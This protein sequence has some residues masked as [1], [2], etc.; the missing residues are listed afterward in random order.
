MA[1][2]PVSESEKL[3][4]LTPYTFPEKN[5]YNLKITGSPKGNARFSN[6]E[7]NYDVRV[8][9]EAD[10]SNSATEKSPW[11]SEHLVHLV[12]GGVIV[13]FFI[14]AL[15]IQNKRKVV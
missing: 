3:S 1:L 10:V 9:R 12:G 11:L 8:S 6:F 4:S 15:I 14:V 7:I 13:I 5:I 2:T